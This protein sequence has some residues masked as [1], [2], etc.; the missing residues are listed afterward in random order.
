[1][2]D[3][4]DTRD[5][6]DLLSQVYSRNITGFETPTGQAFQLRFEAQSPL[7]EGYSEPEKWIFEVNF[8]DNNLWLHK[9]T[10]DGTETVWKNKS[11]Y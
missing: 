4:F 11:R 1:M 5:V 9:R 8:H 2:S 6:F 10:D 3:N 7:I